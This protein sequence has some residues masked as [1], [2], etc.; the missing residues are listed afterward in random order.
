MTKFH[1]KL[2]VLLG[3][4]VCSLCLIFGITACNSGGEHKHKFGGFWL[5][6]GEDGH[7][8][9]ATCHPEVKSELEPHV[10]ETGDFRCDFCDY[11]MHVHVDED[12]DFK[13]D[14]CQ[15][16]I[17]KH[18]FEE[19]WTFNEN[20][21]WHEAS[22]DHF[23]ERDGYAQHEFVDGVCECGVKESEVKVYALYKNS[24]EY[25]LYFNEWL[26]WLAENDIIEVEITASGDGI[27]HYSDGTS[28]M[29]F[30]GE[31][32]V[33]VKAES[34]NGAVADA[35]FMVCMYTRKD[36]GYYSAN[37]TI[38]LGIAK[39]DE[40]GMA[41]IT[42][43]PV[44]G[45]TSTGIDYHVRVALAADVA[46]IQGIKEEDARPLPDRYVVS[47]DAYISYEVSENS[48]EETVTYKISFSK[49]WNG[50]EKFTLPYHRYY[51]NPIEA[52]GLKGNGN[53]KYT[54]TTSGNNLFD[55]FYFE[56]YFIPAGFEPYNYPKETATKIL[57]NSYYAAS[58]NYKISFAIEGSATAT[59]YFWDENGVHLD[60]FHNTK[61]DGTP[62]DTYITSISGGTAGTG[63]YTGGNFVNVGVSPNKATRLFQFGLL[64]DSQVTVTVTVAY[65]GSYES[66]YLKYNVVL[67]EDGSGSVSSVTLPQEEVTPI[68]LMNVSA[69]LYKIS[70]TKR[71]FTKHCGQVNAWTDTDKV[72]KVV[73]CE[74]STT[75]AEGSVS[76]SGIIRLIED[77][78]I[79]Y[80]ENNF[81]ELWSFTVSIEKYELPGLTADTL[82]NIPVSTSKMAETYDIS[83][84][85]S[86]SGSYELTIN[87]YG[88][89]SFGSEKFIGGEKYPLT[90]NIGGSTFTLNM[91]ERKGNG[92]NGYVYTYSGTVTI[93]EGDNTLSIVSKTN[94][95]LFARVI[96]TAA[97]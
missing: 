72:N 93:S 64:C 37:G 2:L 10:D 44:G 8:R 39:T 78:S 97:V 33:K 87:V 14:E 81:S 19:E 53:T 89:E 52:T 74:G 4:V 60:G 94:Y 32:T 51:T 30:V 11:V 38:A 65:V 54:F 42:F 13:C 31:R 62:S 85:R 73:I 61:S 79:I 9:Y 48:G 27:Y 17:H 36:N 67:D 58:G 3:A 95:Q 28:E 23:I 83:L 47:K 41:E 49:G 16:V 46:A 15:T 18:T 35:W 55:Y 66:D 63:K 80:L 25:E 50:I 71:T 43:R 6:D 70:I 77:T 20:K 26:D 84:D 12:G 57:E 90:V 45:Y 34:T 92:A 24:P 88:S 40:N 69:G 29:R 86:L 21:H 5:F 91:T 76:Y 59:L 56:P 82:T 1:K 22:C 96:L 75:S 68:G 7:Y